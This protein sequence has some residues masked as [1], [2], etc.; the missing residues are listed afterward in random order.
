MH[1]RIKPACARPKAG[2]TISAVVEVVTVTQPLGDNETK[3]HGK[4]NYLGKKPL[5]KG[6]KPLPTV[7]RE[8]R[9]TGR[10]IGD[11]EKIIAFVWEAPDW[12]V[13]DK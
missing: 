1:N 13:R 9:R 12:E 5:R 2:D 11:G 4:V 8:V 10:Y 3:K 7:Q 6:N